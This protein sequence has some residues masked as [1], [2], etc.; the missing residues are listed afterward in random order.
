MNMLKLGFGILVLAASACSANDRNA[1]DGAAEDSA[2]LRGVSIVMN[3]EVSN[4]VT[5]AQDANLVNPWGVAFNPRGPIWISNTG[6]GTSTVYDDTGKLLLTVTVPNAAGQSGPSSPTGQVFN[7][8]E[9]AFDGDKFIFVTEQGTVSG[10]KPATGVVTKNDRSQVGANYKGLAIAGERIY[11]AD[12]AN[13]RIDTF[14]KSYAL[15]DLG[16]AFVDPTI[17][18]SY[19]PFNVQTLDGKIF[20][21][22]ALRSADGEERT[23]RGRGFVSMFDTD[24]H[25]LGRVASRGVLN[26]PWGLSLAPP[27]CG[28]LAGKLLVGNHGDGKVNVFELTAVPAASAPAP[29][30]PYGRPAPQP[31]PASVAKHLGVVGDNAGH[32]LVIDEL[33]ALAVNPSGALHFTAG[34]GEEE[35]GTYGVI[36]PR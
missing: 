29:V 24:G 30:G 8:T 2:E 33:W 21:A 32:A 14:D 1:D 26:A 20:V 36:T 34:T 16:D 5:D 35:H 23:G 12:F 17:P 25:L 3:A 6:T 28:P 27:S 31:A 22:Y 11:A 7:G 10:W 18:S 15:V 19:A 13:G 4:L 9:T